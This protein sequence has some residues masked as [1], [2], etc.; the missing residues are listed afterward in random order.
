MDV[1][2]IVSRLDA[3]CAS[4]QQVIA[5]R[6]GGT[7]APAATQASLYTLLASSVSNRMYPVQLPEAATHPSIV[8]SVPGVFEGF[9]IT[10]TDVYVLN[11]RGV[12][13]DTLLTLVGTIVTALASSSI[14]VTDRQEEFDQAEG[15]FKVHLEL[16]CSTIAASAQTLPMAFV[17]PVHRYG[18][19]SVFDN[20]TKQ[21]IRAEY[22]ILLVTDNNNIPAL[23]AEVQAALVGW[24]QDAYHHE[25]EY[26]NGAS[27]ESVG[28][29]SLWREVYRDGYYMTQ[30]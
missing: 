18:E 11:I 24:Q 30:A 2:A 5:A 1:S 16:T 8:S 26:S 13:Y 14:D 23:Q 3:Q 12:D 27:V 10:H 20:F 25:M 15:L 21:L 7:V 6:P 4:L 19:L 9:S 22:A 29:L 17:Y 28:A